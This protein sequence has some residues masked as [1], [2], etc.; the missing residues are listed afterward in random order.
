MSEGY[1]PSR[2]HLA[3]HL[4]PDEGPRRPGAVGQDLGHA[5]KHVI[6]GEGIADPAG[7]FGEHLV[8]RRAFP[9][10]EAVG[11]PPSPGAGGL[12][13]EGQHDRGDDAEGRILLAEQGRPAG[14][15]PDVDER[16]QRT[17]S[18][19]NERLAHN[20]VEV[21]EVE[22][23]DRDADRG[24]ERQESTPSHDR[25]HHGIGDEIT[26]DRSRGRPPGTRTRPT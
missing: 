5:R 9:V 21:V 8:G 23:E 26:E 12:E 16:D 4:E 2:S 24:G 25:A 20:D 6:G 15:D 10:H 11:K 19:D 1:A 3:T 18:T 14:N 17:E 22:P 13:G 7:E